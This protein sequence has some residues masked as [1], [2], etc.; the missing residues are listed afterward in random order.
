MKSDST[1]TPG[2]LSIVL[3]RFFDVRPGEARRVGFMAAIL[4]CLLAANNVIK[5]VRDA[6]FLSHFPIAQLPY[7]YLLAALVAGLVIGL[8]SRYTAKLLLSSVIL[9][10]LAFTISNVI[11]F[12]F[13]VVFY[14]PGW[15]LYAYY[16]WSAIAGM[17]LVAQFWILANGMF[18]PRDGK[19]LFGIITAGGTLGAM[20]GG[21]AANWTVS[22][23]FGSKNLLWLVVA[24]LAGAF[25]MTC[26]AL[27]E[28]ERFVT[29]DQPEETV[30]KKAT[31]QDDV[32]IIGTVLGSRYL[33]TI[34]A[35][36]FVSVVVSTLIDYQFKAAAKASYPTA[37]ALAGFFGSYYA[38]LGAVTM[39][40]QLWLT[41]KV[42]MGFGLTPSLLVLP[43]TLLAGSASL[44]V[45]P[46]L[47]AATATRMVEATLR[48]SVNQSGVQIL[49]LPIADAIKKR[50]KVFLDVAVER[51]G[52][53]MAAM[54][55]L[56]WSLVFGASEFAHLSYFSIAVGIIWIVLIS[57]ARKG[58]LDA[59][60]RS[61][62][63]RDASLEAVRIDFTDKATLD[64]VLNSLDG[65]DEPAVLFALDLVEK[66]DRQ[67]VIAHLARFPLALLRHD[68]PEVRR[69]ALTLVASSLEPNALAL[70]FE[71]LTSESNQARLEAVDT[72]SRLLKN[73]AV[74][75]SRPLLKSSGDQGQ[76][77][78]LRS[79]L[80][81]GDD[82]TRQEAFY[83]LRDLLTERSTDGEKNRIEAARLMG[84]LVEPEF[85]GH[86]I[87]LIRDDPSPAV[88]REAMAAAAR[89]KYPGVIQEVI[90][91]LGANAT[92]AAAREALTQ[93][94]EMAVAGLR[95]ALFDSRVSRD[96][97]LN[98]PRT[99]SKIHAQVAMT[100][101][102][103]G[104][105]EEDH[106][107]RFKVILAIEE[108]SRRLADIKVDRGI[109]ESA[110]I[111]DAQLYCRRLVIF[112]ALFGDRKNSSAYEKSLLYHA[113]GE[114]MDRVIQ[115]IM[116]LL[117][118]LYPAKDIRRAWSGL[119]SAD[120]LQRAHAT[121]FIDNLLTGNIKKYMFPL[122]SDARPDQRLRAALAALAINAMHADSAL[123]ALL[124]QDDRWLKA[125]TVW[126]IGIRKL[127]GFRDAISKLE[128][129]D[130]AVIRE[131]ASLVVGGI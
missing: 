73:T 86:L 82:Q 92:K 10:S 9:G 2:D 108:M 39:L 46:G 65:K 26:L 36:I 55:I 5:V 75:T 111:A 87:R 96:I 76:A 72:V 115:R 74:S 7:V 102:M 34:G 40:A 104:L 114:S 107:I 14:N 113:L 29:A 52:D 112:S 120:A 50:V 101:L 91:R 13:L 89:G 4:F 118:L 25:A 18:N 116:W 70:V 67:F 12:W 15:G 110:I 95:N 24:F 30:R 45:W 44:L 63:F 53:G 121:E 129:S 11:A 41:G 85:A 90:G 64:A 109:V 100:A 27:K 119:T 79:M 117:A 66:M 59:L 130:D 93:Y 1:K 69:R 124:A 16:I 83:A 17:V 106:S 68:S 105:L 8:Y 97:R 94:G 33:K 28:R 131:T 103:G 78:A 38:W 23:L 84:E 60:R 51:L 49:Y 47:V 31:A 22:F 126:E 6:L 128:K 98:I 122:Y 62:T 35:L 42:L 88:V 125:A 57:S 3:R 48:T 61:L 43:V 81:S 80:Q 32:G 56:S 71:L 99:L 58:Y 20:I 127:H 54:I 21:I 37:D 19:R 77:S 123:R